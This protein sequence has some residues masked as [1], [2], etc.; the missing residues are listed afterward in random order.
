MRALQNLHF[1]TNQTDIKTQG[2][3]SEAEYEVETEFSLIL[4]GQKN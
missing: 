1:T 2:S 3:N 4:G